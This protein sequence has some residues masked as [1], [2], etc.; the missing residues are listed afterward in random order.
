M[1]LNR[2]PLI[3]KVILVTTLGLLGGIALSWPLWYAAGREIFPLLPLVGDAQR[4]AVWR[5]QLSVGLLLLLLVGVLI[6]PT[7]KWLIAALL[8]WLAVL[9]CLDI[10]RLQPWVWLYGLVFAGAA[11]PQKEA[12]TRDT[13][14]WL[15]AAVYA[16]SGFHKL[17]PYFAEDNFAWFLEAFFFTKPLA[18]YPILGYALAVLEIS[19]AFGLLWPRSRSIFRWLAIGFHFVIVLLLSPLGLNWNA[20]V[21]PWNLTLAGLVWLIYADQEPTFL[22]KNNGQRLLLVLAGVAP[23]LNFFGAWPHPLSWKLYSNTQPEATFYAPARSFTQTIEQEAM[24][25]KNSFDQSTK[26]LL[27]DWAMREIHTPMFASE[28]T[29]RQTAVYLCGCNLQRDSAGLYILTVQA[30]NRRNEQWQKISC[31]DL[32]KKQE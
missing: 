32:L 3:Q 21:I 5:S 10:N 13:W 8:A 18:A 11:F 30:W 29:F 20:V 1:T 2:L 15:L 17:T 27:D 31:R 22:P 26:L 12:A 9:C 4:E 7:K 28:R 6:F 24:W 23:L 16:W 25:E 14:R 19:L